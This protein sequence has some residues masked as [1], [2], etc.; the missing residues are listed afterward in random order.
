[1]QLLRE[2]VAA[3][4]VTAPVARGDGDYVMDEAIWQDATVDATKATQ[5]E[6]SGAVQSTCVGFAHGT[7]APSPV[8]V[9]AAPP[10]NVDNTNPD[11]PNAEATDGM[12]PADKEGHLC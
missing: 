4:Q 10:N 7:S 5:Q 2:Q 8:D 6:S 11:P 1:M 9:P 12:P 3:V